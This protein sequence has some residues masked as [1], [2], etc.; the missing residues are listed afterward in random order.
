MAREKISDQEWEVFLG[1]ADRLGIDIRPLL[2]EDV[3]FHVL[4]S[5]G[6][7]SQG[8]TALPHLRT[9]VSAGPWRPYFGDH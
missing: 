4:E 1:V 2:D 5:A 3:R 9:L 7:T 6:G 8:A